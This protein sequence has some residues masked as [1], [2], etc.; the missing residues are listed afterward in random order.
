MDL[1]R[2]ICL[3]AHHAERRIAEQGR[4]NSKLNVIGDVKRLG[5]ELQVETSVSA[6]RVVLEEAEIHV[7]EAVS[8]HVGE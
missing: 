4:R 1:P 6:E 7:V 8:S 3:T 5:A 2:I